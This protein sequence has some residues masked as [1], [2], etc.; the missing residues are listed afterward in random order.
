MYV[1]SVPTTY[2]IIR[3]SVP[4]DHAQCAY[5]LANHFA[6]TPHGTSPP[7]THA[8]GRLCGCFFC[9]AFMH[10]QL[11]LGDRGGQ[12]ANPTRKGSGTPPIIFLRDYCC[13]DNCD[14][15]ERPL[16]QMLQKVRC[17]AIVQNKALPQCGAQNTGEFRDSAPHPRR[18]NLGAWLR[19][20][21]SMARAIRY[22]PPTCPQVPTRVRRL[23]RRL[24][25][26][27]LLSFRIRRSISEHCSLFLA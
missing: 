27:Y 21:S 18:S 11:I 10:F 12:V 24:L 1:L 2:C 20:T 19:V 13:V 22:V 16:H 6:L 5:D 26:I 23:F 15:T 4:V 17:T 3:Y 7:R 25:T 9:S 14:F 8:G